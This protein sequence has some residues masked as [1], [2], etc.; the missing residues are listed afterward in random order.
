MKQKTSIIF[1]PFDHEFR[2]QKMTNLLNWKV[3]TLLQDHTKSKLNAQHMHVHEQKRGKGGRR[4]GGWKEEITCNLIGFTPS[5]TSR[6]KRDCAN[7]ARAAFLHI[8]TGPSWQ[9]SPTR[10]T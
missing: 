8:I 4:E 3:I 1:Y 9:W 10:T 5:K 2:K 7:P 6:S